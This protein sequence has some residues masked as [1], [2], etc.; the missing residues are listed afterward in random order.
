MSPAVSPTLQ[1]H[2]LAVLGRLG[3]TVLLRVARDHAHL[4]ILARR[5]VVAVGLPAASESLLEGL[6]LAVD[7]GELLRG[8][9]G[10]FGP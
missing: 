1:H 9:G 10:G 2:P 3:L 7:E 8:Q 6:A 5:S 4:Q